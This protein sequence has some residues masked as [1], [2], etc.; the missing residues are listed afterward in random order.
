MYCACSEHILLIVYS[1]CSGPNTRYINIRYTGHYWWGQGTSDCHQKEAR[2]GWYQNHGHQEDVVRTNS[3][4]MEV[5]MTILITAT[6]QVPP[7]PHFSHK[8]D[9]FKRK[10]NMLETVINEVLQVISVLIIV[11]IS[12][13]FVDVSE[14]RTL[15]SHVTACNRSRQVLTDLSGTISDGPS[16]LN[17]TG[18]VKNLS[19]S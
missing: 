6:G 8:D 13:S 17:Y 4:L 16:Y 11:L 12:V 14:A 9:N 1:S 7:C 18:K 2:P 19:I 3:R 5:K 15:L 10:S